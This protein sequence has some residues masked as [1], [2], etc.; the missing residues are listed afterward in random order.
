[1]CSDGDQKLKGPLLLE[2]IEAAGDRIII[3]VQK[4]MTSLQN[5]DKQGG[6]KYRNSL[7]KLQPFKDE[8]GIVRV[9]GRL[10]K[11]KMEF[12]LKHPVILPKGHLLSNLIVRWCHLRT[13]HSGKGLTINEVRSCGYWIIGISNQAR[14][15]IAKCVNCRRFRGKPM[16]QKM[17]DLPFDRL[18]P[19]PPF[20]YA[21]VD[22]F[23]PFVVKER[24]SN[25]K[26]YVGLFTCL[27]SRAVHLEST[28]SLD[29][30]AFI[31]MLR[32][33]IARRGNVRSIRSDN[34]TNFVGANSELRRAMNEMD[35]ERINR[36]IQMNGGEWMCWKRNPPKA[37][38]MGGIWERQI[39]SARSILS[40]LLL[41][42]G[43]SL[44]D[45]SFRTLL[46]EV[47]AILNSKP[48]TYQN[49]NDPNS[50]LPL[51]PANLLTMKSKLIMPPPGV[52]QK[53]D[54]YCR[55]RWRRVQHIANEFWTRWRK[56]YLNTL[57]ERSKWLNVKKN[58][59][60]GDVVIINEGDQRNNWRL[61]RVIEINKSDD[62]N[63]RSC[64]LKTMSG[65]LI[66][67]INK[68]VLLVEDEERDESQK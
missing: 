14:S 6:K 32:R 13:A 12:G 9:G 22:M 2:E 40:S 1:M 50:P 61:G 66:R 30:D 15:I 39:R 52:F 65:E 3:L 28:A 67:P 43:E 25:I 57:Q 53:A 54:L 33:F 47:E 49:L 38:H 63:V 5:I 10:A 35:H 41:T 26:R 19:A 17:A 16:E 36:F 62:G 23:G 18:E 68:L 31:L 42:H 21:A 48:L 64:K 56:E 11:S 59:Q 45:E 58:L 20:T 44:N 7:M 60:E 37:S 4:N 55:R 24:R 51:S 34:G 46:T 29:T 8:K 27:T